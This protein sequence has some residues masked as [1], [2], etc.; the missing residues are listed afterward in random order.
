MNAV[1]IRGI[2]FKDGPRIMS[3]GTRD[4]RLDRGMLDLPA[5]GQLLDDEQ[6]VEHELGSIR[7]DAQ[8]QRSR[9]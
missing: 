4:E 1:L 6:R 3:L 8:D 9:Q 7:A 5:A 2:P